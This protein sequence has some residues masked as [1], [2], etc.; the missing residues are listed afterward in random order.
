MFAEHRYYGNS[1]PLGLDSFNN[2]ILEFLSSE[3][4]LADYAYLIRHLKS[5]IPGAADSPVITFG[6]SYGT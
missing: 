5:T 3:Q 1:L 4:A 2:T 6:G